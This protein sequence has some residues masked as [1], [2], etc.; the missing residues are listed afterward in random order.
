MRKQIL[1]LFTTLI[2][3]SSATAF[4]TDLNVVDRTATTEDPAVFNLTVENPHDEQERF[5]ISSI[6]APP[7]ASNWVD[8]EY[9]KNVP[10]NSEDTFKIR[11]TPSQDAIQ[12]N[13]A[14]TVNIRS[15]DE[16]RL[17]K[18]DSYFSVFNEYNLRISSFQI[19][20]TNPSPGDKLEVS[21]TVRNTAGNSL[22]DF[23]VDLEGFNKTDKKQGATLGS[24]D[25]IRYSFS[26][27]VPERI[28]PGNQTVELVIYNSGEEAQKVSQV[29][30]VQE[31]RSIEK[32]SS[33]NDKL[34]SRV[35]TVKAYNE[36]NVQDTV[37]INRSLPSYLDPLVSFEPETDSQESSGN[38]QIYYWDLRLEPGEE[39][40]VEYTV[41]Y[42][43]ALGFILL[44]FVGVLGIKKLQTDLKV[45]KT[46]DASGDQ[47]KVVIE[48]EN[49]SGTP[50]R[51]IEVK[52]FVPD[53]AEVSNDFPMAKPVKTKTSSGTRLTWKIGEL[54]PGEQR[55]F[56]Y[57]INPIVEVEGGV[58]LP[59][60][61]V[62]KD[63]SKVK[64]TGEVQVDFKPE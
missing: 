52:D 63:G 24:G 3:I 36:G 51:N 54:N 6:L 12:Q 18:L 33:E 34:L 44:V 22:E 59:V 49:N 43:P 31:Y 55:V 4:H 1:L 46:T 23:R 30:E 56:E 25:S 45:S 62:V 60:A 15:F 26:L 16:N 48:I 40:Q 35:Y 2:V 64:E 28:P 29:V 53:I 7:A 37:S 13:Y 39:R 19:S 42:A 20:D 21:A 11:V 17:E 41:D 38:N 61:E 10:A 57:R 9:S 58:V 32:E 8:Y 5:W 14:F 27:D 50:L 47:V